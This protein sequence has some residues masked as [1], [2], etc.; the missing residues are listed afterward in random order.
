[1]PLSLIGVFAGPHVLAEN[2]SFILKYPDSLDYGLPR[3]YRIRAIYT[4]SMILKNAIASNYSI[5]IRFY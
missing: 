1:M 4:A 2:P 3:M 5:L